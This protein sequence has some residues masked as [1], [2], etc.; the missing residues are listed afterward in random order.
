MLIVSTCFCTAQNLPSEPNYRIAYLEAFI[1]G[2]RLL[3]EEERF[4]YLSY[5]PL[6][7]YNYNRQ[8]EEL[9]VCRSALQGM[10]AKGISEDDDAHQKKVEKLEHFKQIL[11]R[12]TTRFLGYWELEIKIGQKALESISS[13]K[14][15]ENMQLDYFYALTLKLK[16]EEINKMPEQEKFLYLSDNSRIDWSFQRLM[17][18]KLR[19]EKVLEKL[20]SMGTNR[21]EDSYRQ[22]SE[23]LKRVT[24]GLRLEADRMMKVWAFKAINL[25]RA[26]R[27][28]QTKLEEQEQQMAPEI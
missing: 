5:T 3:P 10:K 17:E 6:V 20:E 16:V 24:E 14:V 9:L 23:G 11:R 19:Y 13:L 26:W 15:R 2:I 8:V 7:N 4:V 21:E 18:D 1:E 12:E 27:K 25:H 28:A 22:A